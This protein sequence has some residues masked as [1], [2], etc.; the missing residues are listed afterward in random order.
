MTIDRSKVINVIVIGIG[1][2]MLYYSSTV[3][4]YL[5]I[6]L[7]LALMLSPVNQFFRKIHIKRV[8]IPDGAAAGLTMALLSI[9]LY[10][11]VSLFVP[12]ISKE[13]N[14][15]AQ[16]NMDDVYTIVEPKLHKF[17]KVVNKISN[18]T[19]SDQNEKDFIKNL[20]MGKQNFEKVPRFFTG[21]ASGI[22][23]SIIALFSIFFITFF[24]LKDDNLFN[25]FVTSL[26]TKGK[27]KKVMGILAK[28]KATLTR[29]FIGI[30]IQV[31]VVTLIVSAGLQLMGIRNALVIGLFAGIMNIIPYVGPLIGYSFGLLIGMSTN[32]DLISED[33]VFHLLGTITLVF[34][35]SQAVDNFVTQPVVFSKSISAHPL[36]VFLV[37][38]IAGNI[39]GIMGMI[40]AIPFYSVVRILAREHY[41]DSRFVQF[42]T[43]KLK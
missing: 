5:T 36:E 31:S 4:I 42:M 40:I 19:P 23:G 39:W 2:W 13:V 9:C 11:I 24:L 33:S 10:L 7:I 28:V 32:L 30:F 43:Q 26:T 29:Y 3:L 27:E 34:G 6:S 17:S 21:L 35:I 16:V 1:I 38:L 41:H 8:R 25:D 18:E 20:V 37:I 12:I 14:I 15:L 22:G